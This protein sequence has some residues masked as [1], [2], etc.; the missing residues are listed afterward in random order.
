MHGEDS[1][2]S[3]HRGEHDAETQMAGGTAAASR[4]WKYRKISSQLTGPRTLLGLLRWAADNG[5]AISAYAEV[6]LVPP[7]VRMYGHNPSA[8]TRVLGQYFA[9]RFLRADEII[10]WEPQLDARAK[11]LVDRHL[12]KVAVL[13]REGL[14]NNAEAFLHHLAHEVHE[15]EALHRIFEAEGGSMLA[16]RVHELTVPARDVPN[17]HFEAWEWA[18][19]LIEGLRRKIR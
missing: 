1:H 13:L 7:I 6:R 19:A 5:V 4:I 12:G 2:G 18:D 9:F 11:S 15:L 3:R 14:L 10:Y 8:G 16:G 17:L